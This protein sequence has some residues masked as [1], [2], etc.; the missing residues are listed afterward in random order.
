MLD[1]NGAGKASSVIEAIDWAIEHRREFNIRVMNLSLGAPA[2]QSYR[3]DPLCE[4]A[5]RATAAGI[6]VVAAAGNF[7]ITADGKRIFG[8]ITAPGND[9]SVITV[10]ALDT[11]GTAIRSDDAIARFSSR[12]PT[13]YDHI[14]KPD[15]VAP[16]RNV[17]SA[18]ASGSL[19]AAQ[20]P[21]RHVTGSGANG[22]IQLSGSSMSAGVVSGAVALL[23]ERRP[24]L[25]PADARIVLQ[26]TSS[27]LNSEGLVTSGAGSLN[28]LAAAELVDSKPL[29]TLTSMR[30]SRRQRPVDYRA[31]DLQAIQA[32][33]QAEGLGH[34]HLGSGRDHHLGSSEP[35]HDHWGQAA[36][37]IWGGQRQPRSFG[38]SESDQTPSFG[39]RV[40]ATPSFG[41]SS[42][43]DT[44]IWGQSAPD[45]II[46]GQT[47]APDTIVW[48][49]R[50][51][52]DTIIWGQQS[53]RHHYLGSERVRHDHLGPIRERRHH[54]LGKCF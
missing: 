2:L 29:G 34:D 36:T 32:L 16:G 13:M 44:I 18:E 35:R 12:G 27:F 31:R 15:L 39:A 22:Y 43:R 42:S 46:W 33:T 30:G 38:V 17:V 40:P 25:G 41:A 21:E 5:E 10:G 50:Q 53:Q 8:G 1:E 14:I 9:P 48:G 4:A 24:K 51:F 37:T 3:D 6:I 28:A 23:L 19:L 45:T 26:A 54:R 47:A 52:V 20:Y 7:G 49:A 11:N